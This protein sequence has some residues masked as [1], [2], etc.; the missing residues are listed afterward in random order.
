M[1]RGALCDVT[2]DEGFTPLMVASL[3]GHTEVVQELLKGGADPKMRRPEQ[4]GG[5]TALHMVTNTD[6]GEVLRALLE[7]GADPNA[8]ASGMDGKTPLHLAAEFGRENLAELL[9]NHPN[10]AVDLRDARDHTPARLA[11]ESCPRLSLYL[12]LCCGAKSHSD[13]VRFWGNVSTPKLVRVCM[14]EEG[15]QQLQKPFCHTFQV[16]IVRQ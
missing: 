13:K 6:E 5:D 14:C 7:A 3:N 15:R 12:D 10:C 11:K 4:F 1:D 8:C 16:E 9:A 2:D